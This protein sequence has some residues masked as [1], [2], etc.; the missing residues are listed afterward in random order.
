MAEWGRACAGDARRH[1]SLVAAE[2]RGK[3]CL[4]F[5][6]SSLIF[7]L[8]IN[9]VSS[10]VER[11]AMERLVLTPEASSGLPFT[12]TSPSNPKPGLV[13]CQWST[14]WPASLKKWDPTLAHRLRHKTNIT[15]GIA[16][17]AYLT[18]ERQHSEVGLKHCY[19]RGW[20]MALPYIYQDASGTASFG[21]SKSISSTVSRWRLGSYFTLKH[22]HWGSSSNCLQIRRVERWSNKTQCET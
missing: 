9:S 22:P 3:E 17:A 15:L 11:P 16:K 10:G 14:C 18:S 1:C 4:Y 19:I 8:R 7:M 21:D 2:C 20:P 13:F 12:I 5:R 6:G